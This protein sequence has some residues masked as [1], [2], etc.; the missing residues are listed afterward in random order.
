MTNKKFIRTL[1][2]TIQSDG[3]IWAT[4][5]IYAKLSLYHSTH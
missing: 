4:N 3:L 1:F 5:E 2:S